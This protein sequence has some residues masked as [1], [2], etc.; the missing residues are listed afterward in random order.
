MHVDVAG[1]IPE[2][3]PEVV[4]IDLDDAAFLALLSRIVASFARDGSGPI[5]LPGVSYG[6]YD[7][8]YE[9]EGAFTAVLGC[10]TWAA[11]VLR[12]GGIRTGWWNPLPQSLGW[13]IRSFNDL[14]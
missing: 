9:A 13:S 8:F 1:D 10:N 3:H 11:S 4:G 6:T 12:A 14:P 5:H 2:P 7:A